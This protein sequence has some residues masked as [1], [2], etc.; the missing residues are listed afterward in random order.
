MQGLWKDSK[1]NFLKDKAERIYNRYLRNNISEKGS[2]S[3]IVI[4][5]DYIKEESSKKEIIIKV[6]VEKV[7]FFKKT[8]TNFDHSKCENCPAR[9]KTEKNPYPCTLPDRLESHQKE[10]LRFKRK[11]GYA[12]K[13]Y[14]DDNYRCPITRTRMFFDIH[15][16]TKLV[17]RSILD[18]GHYGDSYNGSSNYFPAYKDY[19]SGSLISDEWSYK[20]TISSEKTNK[21]VFEKVVET[22][23]KTKYLK[24]LYDG[25]EYIHGEKVD[26]LFYDKYRSSM[27]SRKTYWKKQSN[28]TG[29]TRVKNWL[30]SVKKD[31]SKADG[32][33]PKNYATEKSIKWELH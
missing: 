9:I 22:T 7:V 14:K 32:T 31:L 18:N 8:E 11:A 19:Y 21:F 30:D 13:A 1:K 24:H 25:L 17:Y 33:S 15:E 16:T 26:Y 29:R 6:P 3:L 2:S 23:I 12:L 5:E 20:E 10:E 27:S 28:K 4:P